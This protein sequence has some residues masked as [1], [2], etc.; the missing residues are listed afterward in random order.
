MRRNF[1]NNLTILYVLD[2]DDDDGSVCEEITNLIWYPNVHNRP[3]KSPRYS[4]SVP[5]ESDHTLSPYF[6]HTSAALQPFVGP[7]P[8]LHFR[9]LGRTPWMS[10]QPVAKP[11]PTHR[12]TQTQN[13][14]TVGFEPRI[15]AFERAKTVHA[16]DRAAIVI[17][18][19]LLC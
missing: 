4:Y 12:K 10:D 3:H 5:D 8:L 17:G 19:T 18:F 14:R 7:W 2:D 9:N 6:I 16:L 11:L 13:K 1:T 15:P